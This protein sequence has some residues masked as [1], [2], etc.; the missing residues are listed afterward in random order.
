MRHVR[1]SLSIMPNFKEIFSELNSIIKLKD[2]EF[3]FSYD[4]AFSIVEFYVSPL[5]NKHILFEKNPLVAT[6]FLI[7]ERKL[8][9]THDV[10][11]LKRLGSLVKPLKGLPIFTDVD[12]AIVTYIVRSI[13]E[14]T[15]LYQ[16]G[17]LRYL[18]QDG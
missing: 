12:S 17:C 10:F 18:R 15:A 8:Q 6:L 5:V 2:K 7:H 9:K 16:M 4:T 3:L 11:S 14:N 1:R 13:K